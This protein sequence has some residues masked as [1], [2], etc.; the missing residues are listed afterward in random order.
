M[1]KAPTILAIES[2]CDETSA[3]VVHQGKVLNNIIATQSIHENYGG[4]VPELAS[5][6]HISNIVPVVAAALTKAGIEPQQLDA[7]AFTRGPG[8]LGALLVGT[9]FAKAMALG[10]DIPMIAVDHM[11]AHVVA[12]FIEPPYPEFPFL[13]LTVSGGHT[14]ILLVKDYLD[15]EV[16]GSTQDDAVGEAFDKIAKMLG[17]PYPGGPMLDQAAA[18]GN[19]QAFEFPQ[20]QMAGLDFSFSG[21]KTAVL[22]FLRDQIKTNPDFVQ[23]HIN[24]ICASVQ[25]T[26][27]QMLMNQLKAA[28]SEYGIKRVAIAG[29]VS[30]NRG[31][32]N[33]L[34]QLAVDLNWQVFIPE[35]QYCTDNAAM[36]AITAH[37][38]YLKGEFAAMDVGP[39]PRLRL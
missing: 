3:A 18:K 33:E 39:D 21:I 32:R 29:G 19:P 13:C 22:Y 26:L 15:M 37:Y 31:L 1:S 8:L 9:S 28:A 7:I 23:D 27:I 17:F 36:I 24:D 30:A 6:A 34:N 4:V 12:H 14:Q 35:L 38:K 16:I 25:H 2:S 11:Q 5:R 10:L 20:T